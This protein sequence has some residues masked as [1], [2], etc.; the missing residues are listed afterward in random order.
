MIVARIPLDQ[1]IAALHHTAE[2]LKTHER[3]TIGGAVEVLPDGRMWM[4]YHHIRDLHEHV[5]GDGYRGGHYVSP[6]WCQLLG[7]KP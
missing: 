2:H 7:R 5:T 4:N 1:L 3:F 6:G